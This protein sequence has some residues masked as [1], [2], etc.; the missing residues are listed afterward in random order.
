MRV[1]PIGVYF[2]RDFDA[3]CAAA[4]GDA[5]LTHDSAEAEAGSV[6]IALA[7]AHGVNCSDL[8]AYDTLSAVLAKLRSEK[9]Q[10]TAVYAKIGHVR[11]L[12]MFPVA[13][14]TL[15]ATAF[16]SG[17][18]VADTVATA[19]Y[20]G[21]MPR[22]FKECITASI[23][24]GGDTDTRTAIVGAIRAPRAGCEYPDAWMA[25]EERETLL[26]LGAKLYGGD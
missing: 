13:A 2:H 14:E 7:V 23:A 20:F 15:V 1:S 5:I 4:R 6:A 18:N 25:V 3:L 26:S 16:D 8:N 21:T 17:G 10:H 19:L 11:T 9:L 24:M 12:S 22:S